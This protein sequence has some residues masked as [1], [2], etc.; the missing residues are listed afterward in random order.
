MKRRGKYIILI[1]IFISG[2]FALNAEHAGV[3]G[4]MYDLSSHNLSS[5]SLSGDSIPADSISADSI[6]ENIISADSSADDTAL[7]KPR[8]P[9]KKTIQ[10]GYVGDNY[11]ELKGNSA[12]DLRDPENLKTSVEY[13]LKTN[14]YLIKSTVG[15]LKLG[16]PLKMTSE[17][18]QK[19]SLRQSMDEYFREKTRASWDSI[20]GGG[21][22]GGNRGDKRFDP[23]NIQF[24][25]GPADKIFG[26][27]G[28]K[29][30]SQGTIGLD[31]GLKSS[32]TSNPALPEKSRSRTFFNFNTDV[33]ANMV[34]SVGNKVNFD[35]NYN[36]GAAFEF[37]QSK[38][39]LNYA[40]DED[41]IVKALEGGN[42]SLQTNNSL[43][44][45]GSALFGVKTDLQ[46]GKLRVKA[47]VAQQESDSRTISS[48][49]GSQ[50]TDYEITVDK[51]DENRHYFLSHYFRDNYDKALAK[52]PYISSGIMI[53]RIEVW[54]TNKSSVHGQTRNI[55]AFADLG[56][57]SHISNPMFVPAGSLPVP[58]NNANSLYST[59]VSSY[60]GAR[61]IST[62]T[63]TF[64]G[65]I[66]GGRDYE[67]IESARML[68]A[69]DYKFNNQLGYI[70]LTAK[71]QADEVL[72]VAFEYLYNGTVYQVGEFSSDKTEDTN[73]CL[74][75]KVLKGTSLSPSMPFW[76]LMMKNI[77]AIPSAYSVQK[78]KFRLDI[79]Y[80]SD[81]AGTYVY[82]IPEGNIREK[83][84]LKV[85]NLDRLNTN[86]EVVPNAQ[87]DGFFDF[88]EGYTITA[89]NGRIIFPV[90][91]PFGK[92]LR[93][94]IGNDDIADKYVYQELY[95]STLT[96]AKQIAEKNKFVIRGQYSGSSSSVLSLGATNVARGSVVVRANGIILTE[97][98]DY[99]VNYTSG[100][101]SI[102][103]ETLIS[104][105]AN[106]S[107]ALENQATSSMQRKSVFG[108]DI[109]YEVSK[110]LNVGTT[111]MHLSEMPQTTK[112]TF[113]QESV[114]NTLWGL[115]L[116]YKNQSQWL[117]NMFDKLPLLSLTAPSTFSLNAEFAHLIAGHYQN[118]YVGEY[119]YLD[120]FEST[121]FEDD[122]LN[123]Y[124]W[125]ISSTPYDGGKE[126]AQFPEALLSN[127][128][129][130]G[131]NRA[132]LAWYYIDGLFTRRNSSLRPSY[133]TDDHLSDHR[134]RAV[135]SEEI[136]P[137]RD[138]LYTDNN[139]LNIL[140]LAY[141]PNERGP[142][143]LDADNIN[144]DGTLSNPEKR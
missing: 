136:F 52:L 108:T 41:E 81:T 19:Y 122:L 102:L 134:V 111:I 42:V 4:M 72:A 112:T 1:I 13:D 78:A 119:S 132:L 47:I 12:A 141:Y 3:M 84:L 88:V 5:Y 95:D 107:V 142:Y 44:R 63:Q 83:P 76:D 38:L 18:Y 46:F 31:I 79:V 75:L 43:V 139:Y 51:Y 96:I 67:K 97:N 23:M 35:F 126:T 128:I 137:N 7:V 73:Q 92:H 56:E 14:T 27:G 106:I 87:G 99:L 74:Y 37:D 21:G 138:L 135:L 110:N 103:N 105:N 30:S 26:P 109:N 104:S 98:V 117:T 22:V 40:G 33:Q 39:N 121:Q 53:N 116:D 71:L 101:V 59:I 10:E 115:N 127:N 54:I 65:V 86:N 68:S 66:E 91:E 94:A 48:K 80:H 2:I 129:E 32:S 45:G 130:Y 70:S 34:A 120:D 131:K 20:S 93:K 17:E 29:L 114:K 89:I 118:K 55:V 125:N 62:V 61:E 50:M 8:F 28:V 15:D 77:Y 60:P 25:L 90:V 124:S 11:K 24:D 144:S 85:M 49:G 143:N 6:P 58:Y 82:T 69:T 100:T 57:N 16:T 64:D 113:G 36:T 123:P 9:V 140:N 133:I